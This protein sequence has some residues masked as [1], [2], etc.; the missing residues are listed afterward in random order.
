VSDY[1]LMPDLAHSVRGFRHT[2]DSALEIFSTAGISPGRITIRMDG[3]GL[4]SRWVAAQ[5]PAPGVPLTPGET[6]ELQIAGLGYF[7]NLPVACWEA[8][9]EA[10]MGTREILSV[11]DDPYQKAVHWLRE[12]ARLFDI[13]PSNT[14]ACSRWISLFGLVPDHWPAETWYKLALLLP[15]LQSLAG[16][17]YGMGFALR[18]MLDLP[19]ERIRRK[20]RMRYL[21]EEQLSR[22]GDRMSRLGVDSIAGNRIEDLAE[23]VLVLG[24]TPLSTYYAFQDEE[25]QYLLKAVVYLITPCHQRYSIEWSIEDRNRAP[26]LGVE[27]LNSR[28]GLNT[29]LGRATA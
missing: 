9:G 8:G 20:P 26:R 12:G 23:N 2:V 3:P 22:L 6:I 16:K 1:P 14:E 15:S 21:T 29:H 11:V 19:L 28:L 7:H 24:P 17:E 10:E 13:S 25:R 5:K 18:W 4:P 27:H